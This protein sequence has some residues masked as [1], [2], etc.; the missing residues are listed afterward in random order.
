M[1]LNHNHSYNQQIREWLI[2]NFEYARYLSQQNL[3]H[4]DCPVCASANSMFF[5]NNGCLDYV[6]CQ[7]CALVYMNPTLDLTAVQQGFQGDDQ[8]LMDYFAII[9]QYRTSPAIGKPN[10][11]LDN[12]LKD[13]YRYKSRGKLL[14]I[15]C[16]VGDFLY[17]AQYF[18]DVEGL[19]I[20][21]VTAR[22]AGQR[23]RVHSDYL[24]NLIDD[25]FNQFN[26]QYDIV[27]MHQILYGVPDPVGLL[28]NIHT[29]L[30]DDGILY[31]NTPNADSYAMRLYKGKSNHLYGYT[32]QN[33]FNR[34]S[35]EKLAD[36]SGFTVSFFRTE[37]L[38][39][40]YTDIIAYLDD[41]DGGFIHKRNS[42]LPDYEKNIAMEDG[43]QAK[44][45]LDF[46]EHGNYMIAVLTKC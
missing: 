38:D 46:G 39:I 30:K 44:M 40:Y 34:Y 41:D 1:S 6:Q 10:P 36:C 13:I 31:V 14:D 21:P 4:R 37:W 28:K 3:K 5:A 42:H 24:H 11:L 22:I 15:G 27:S 19:E 12:K 17:K 26:K 2:K 35:L 33:V 23:F 45:D 20:N 7:D 43:L 29:I 25:N 18:Y 9:A 32:T 8:L 16:S